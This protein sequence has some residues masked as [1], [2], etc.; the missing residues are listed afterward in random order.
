MTIRIKI[1]MILQKWPKKRRRN[2]IGGKKRW[3]NVVFHN[4]RKKRES[5]LKTLCLATLF[6]FKGTIP[7]AGSIC[8]EESKISLQTRSETGHININ[9]YHHYLQHLEP[10]S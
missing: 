10:C 6:T 1:S 8:D 2:V 4:R 9:K 5:R 7:E 3:K